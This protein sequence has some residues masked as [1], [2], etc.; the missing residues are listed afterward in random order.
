[1]SRLHRCNYC[2]LADI[3]KF[4]ELTGQEVTL[5]PSPAEARGVTQHDGEK[6]TDVLVGGVFVAWAWVIPDH[7]VCREDS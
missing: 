6:G 3:R 7:C 5:R 1:V 2:T 4:A